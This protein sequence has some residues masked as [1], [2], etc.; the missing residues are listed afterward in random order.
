[1]KREYDNLQEVIDLE[2]SKWMVQTMI[3]FILQYPR[4]GFVV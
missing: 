4:P 2:G 3:K 1:M